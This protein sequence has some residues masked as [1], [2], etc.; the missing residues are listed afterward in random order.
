MSP[1]NT[2]LAIFPA[3]GA[4]GTATLQHLLKPNQARPEDVVLVARSPEKLASYQKLG[5][6]VR[7]A[8]YDD[9]STLVHAFDGVKILNLI[10]YASIQHEHRFN[11]H[12]LAIDSAISSGVSHII[13]SSLAFAGP[14][15]STTTVA[16]VMLAHLQTEA[17]LSTIHS[18][19]PT[20]FTYS[21]FRQGIYAE[22]FPIYTAF[23]DLKNPR[24]ER[25]DGKVRIPHDGEGPGG[26]AW[27]KRDELG[28]GTAKLLLEA[29]NYH[30]NKRVD[31]PLPFFFNSTLLLSG[32]KSYTLAQTVSIL[33]NA[34][35]L[36]SS[37]SGQEE[38]VQIEQVSIEEYASQPIV[39]NSLD[40]GGGTIWPALWATAFEGIRRGEAGF[41]TG[42]LESVLGRKCEAFEVTVGKMARL[43]R[44]EGK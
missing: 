40:Y 36:P 25:G 28:E 8:D 9:A 27:V 7:Q 31:S 13:Y 11:V 37:S 4:L 42:T 29:F 41:V 35:S 39:Q 16:Q 12:K 15:T 38:P 6:D 14:P 43:G 3:S 26:M 19:N 17:Y 34:G 20:T 2:K 32:P 22:S 24:G 10:S 33:A 23:F 5:V 30:N 1:S 44:E 21:I 18:Q